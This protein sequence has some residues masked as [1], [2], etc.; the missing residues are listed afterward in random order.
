MDGVCMTR[1]SY[2]FAQKQNITANKKRVVNFRFN[3]PFI[4][5]MDLSC[6]AL[7]I[8]RNNE[9]TEVETT[10]RVWKMFIESRAHTG[11]RFLCT[12][13]PGLP[14][15]G[16]LANYIRASVCVKRNRGA[17]LKSSLKLCDMSFYLLLAITK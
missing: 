8:Y 1:T 2:L 7:Q 6:P 10:Q 11:D 15:D 16:S 9:A 13:W 5:P 4:D 17:V 3:F 12:S 14:H